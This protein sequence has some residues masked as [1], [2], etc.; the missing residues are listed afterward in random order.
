ML[1]RTTIDRGSTAKKFQEEELEEPFQK[2]VELRRQ[3][4]SIKTQMGPSPS[5]QCQKKKKLRDQPKKSQNEI[6]HEEPSV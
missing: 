2:V 1:K 6:T 3:P 5:N 4:S